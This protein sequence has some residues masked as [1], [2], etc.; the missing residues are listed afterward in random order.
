MG[1]LSFNDSEVGR[2]MDIKNTVLAP[3]HPKCC[4]SR[5]IA[6]SHPLVFHSW[7][8]RGREEK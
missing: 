2:D 4:I 5:Q 3:E 6:L 8:G 1:A 7:L